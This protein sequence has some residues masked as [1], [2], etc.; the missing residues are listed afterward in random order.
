[1]GIAMGAAENKKLVGLFFRKVST[2][3]PSI[4]EMLAED[5]VWWVPS[6]SALAG[7]YQGKTRVLELMAS[8]TGRYDAAQP[9]TIEV[10]EMVAEGDSV[11][12]Q[13]VLR[14]TT[15]RGE[16]YEN[17]YHFLFK[18][19]AGQIHKVKEY[20]DTKYAHDKLFS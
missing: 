11:A 17:H 13:M 1:M 12:V 20:V 2:A 10:Q 18:V 7:S 9:L 15:A 6:G 19:R 8:G 14:A 5:V 3:D 16:D 4:A